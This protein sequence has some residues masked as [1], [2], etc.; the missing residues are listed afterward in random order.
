MK[1]SILLLVPPILIIFLLS[2]QQEK[3]TASEISPQK[4]K[5]I[6]TSGKK[7]TAAL[8]TTLK[9]ELFTAIGQSGT[10]AAIDICRTSAIKLTDSLISTM[11]GIANLKRTTLKYRNPEN[12]P[13]KTDME[14]LELYEKVLLSGDS[15]PDFQVREITQN[16]KKMYFYYQPLM[17]QPLCLNCHGNESHLTP[18]IKDILAKNYPED[19][20]IGYK[21]GQFRGAIRVTIND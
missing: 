21:A 18:E 12:A 16:N 10:V 3:N 19:T 9:K 17:V 4:L 13:D 5:K 15:I 14:V 6:V 8:T 11:P 2:C 1:K 20:A 7:A